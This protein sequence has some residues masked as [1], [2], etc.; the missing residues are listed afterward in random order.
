MDIDEEKIG[1]ALV[2]THHGH[3]DAQSAPSFQEEIVRRIEGG[4]MAIVLDLS[5]TDYLSS[6]GLRALLVIA[7][8][9]KEKG[10]NVAACNARE[11]VAEVIKISGF[12]SIINIYPDRESALANI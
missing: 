7:K 2:L 4:D 9:I 11:Q 1:G 12:K 6:A 8:T 10:G 5:D 3:L